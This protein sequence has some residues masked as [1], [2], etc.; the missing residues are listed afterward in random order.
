MKIKDI[1]RILEAEV[2]YYQDEQQMEMEIRSIAASDLMSNILALVRVPDLLL[3]GLNN[4]QVINTASVFGIKAVA[5][6]K[7]DKCPH[8]D[9]KV[10][11][12]A[13][14]EEILLLLTHKCMYESCGLLYSNGL[15]CILG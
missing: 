6:I 10:L 3:T 7:N 11:E 5:L 2:L 8:V 1:Q 4:S 13:K 15:P 9:T 12:L 14:E